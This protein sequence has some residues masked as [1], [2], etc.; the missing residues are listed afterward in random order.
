MTKAELRKK[1][2]EV[3]AGLVEAM[4][5]DAFWGTEVCDAHCE[6]DLDI[7][8]A[9]VVQFLREKERSFK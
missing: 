2:F 8:Q 6:A 1:A 4:D 9:K 5:P 3:A 7:Y